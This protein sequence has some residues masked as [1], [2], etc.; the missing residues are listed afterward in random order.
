MVSNKLPKHGFKNPVLWCSKKQI[1]VTQSTNKVE[2]WDLANAMCDVL[3][4]N[5]FLTEFCLS[6][7]SVTLIWC[8]NTSTISVVANPVQYE[9]MKHVELFFVREK[10]A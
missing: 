5:S 1:M 9:K 4:V 6:L 2:L 7:S 8:D 3:W 10:V